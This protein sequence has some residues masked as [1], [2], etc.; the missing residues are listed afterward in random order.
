MN[1]GLQMF[2][3]RDTAK[4]DMEKALCEVS[5]MGY[6]F[7][8]F[9]GFFDIPAEK[10]KE[11]LDKYSLT[12]YATHTHVEQITDDTI[13]S[14]IA[15][16]KAI[17]CT[18]LIIPGADLKTAA[19]LDAFI[20]QVNKALPILKENGIE[21]HFHNHSRE[22]LPN[23]DGLYIHYEL[24]KRTALKF[25]IDT[26]WAYNAE[27]DPVALMERLKDRI[28]VI[29]LKDGFKGGKGIPLGRGTAPVKEVMNKAKELGIV[30]VV[31][32]ETLTPSGLEEALTCSEFLK[33]NDVYR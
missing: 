19:K 18:N 15:Y 1:Y 29:H 4:V 24:E 33:E 11:M 22:F 17:G 12:A 6:E 23:D 32:S 20:D 7:V 9:A 5:K 28:T 14:T 25:E 3:V 16:H 13:E 26:F 31:E 10:I 30:M 21:L 2:S 8:E 27:R